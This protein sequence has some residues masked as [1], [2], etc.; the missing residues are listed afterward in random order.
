M[1]VPAAALAGRVRASC[2]SGVFVSCSSVLGLLPDYRSSFTDCWLTPGMADT[3]NSHRVYTACTCLVTRVTMQDAVPRSGRFYGLFKR[4]G[5]RV[6]MTGLGDLLV[7]P[8]PLDASMLQVPAGGCC[9]L[10][11]SLTL[12][13]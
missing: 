5:H 11:P 6:V 3:G 13:R 4:A 10:S 12:H 9:G 1:Y 2:G 8:S 7:R